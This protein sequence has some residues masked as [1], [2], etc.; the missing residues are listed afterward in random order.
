MKHISNKEK[1]KAQKQHIN[2]LKQ[3][4]SELRKDNYDLNSI[5]Y[6]L[7]EEN[8]K[9]IE[10]IEKILNNFGT[11]DVDKS[12]M[13]QTLTI[14]VIKRQYNNYSSIYNE[15][16]IQT[17]EIIIPEIKLMKSKMI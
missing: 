2:Y 13:H 4:V 9:L 5:N 15:H 14:P 10:W 1:V 12:Y 8:K 16:V 6:N 7:T 11:N 3:K 17:E